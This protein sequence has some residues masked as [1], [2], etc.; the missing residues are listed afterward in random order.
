MEAIET[1]KQEPSNAFTRL[2]SEFRDG[3]S[4]AELSEALQACVAAA[5]DTG[6][7]AELKYTVKFTPSG[8]AIVVTDKVDIKLPV[9]DRDQAIFFPTE[10]NTLQRDNPAQKTLDLRTVEKPPEQALRQL[11]AMANR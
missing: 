1:T 4:I 6:K 8:N 5:R 3:Q 2:L 11:A 10:Q 7:V 9:V